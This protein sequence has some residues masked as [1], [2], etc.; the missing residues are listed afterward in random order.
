MQDSKAPL[1]DSAEG[2]AARAVPAS[3]LALSGTLRFLSLMGHACAMGAGSF[4]GKYLIPIALL[5]YNCSPF[6]GLAF[7]HQRQHLV[8][9]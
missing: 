1:S 9:D 7:T 5:S 8:A 3:L 2:V 6:A 4:A